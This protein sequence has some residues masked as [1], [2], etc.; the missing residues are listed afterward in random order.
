MRV[1]QRLANKEKLM[2]AFFAALLTVAIIGFGASFVLER[3]QRTADQSY[4][5]VGTRVEADARLTGTPVKH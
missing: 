5:G 1:L 2:K 4:A 3:F